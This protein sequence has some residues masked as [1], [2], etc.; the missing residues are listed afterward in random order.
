MDNSHVLSLLVSQLIIHLTDIKPVIKYWD[1]AWLPLDDLRVNVSMKVRV[2]FCTCK[3]LIK[4]RVNVSMIVRVWFC[5]CKIFGGKLGWVL[6]LMLGFGFAHANFF[7]WAK[8][9]HATLHMQMGTC[10]C[11]IPAGKSRDCGTWSWRLYWRTKRKH[12]YRYFGRE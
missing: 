3:I 4:V 9:V 5:T 8:C 11:A 6:V 1:T 12:F 10:K 7:A 2:W